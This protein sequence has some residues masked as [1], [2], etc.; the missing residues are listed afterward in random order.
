MNLFRSVPLPVYSQVLGRH[1]QIE[2][3]TSYLAV[4]ENR[5]YYSLLTMA[6]LQQC[7]LGL[8]TICAARFPFI[9]CISA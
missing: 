7:H 9:P 5:Q 4:T 2:P 3:E 1:I 6:D 8:I